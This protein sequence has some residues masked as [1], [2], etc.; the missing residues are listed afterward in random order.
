MRRLPMIEPDVRGYLDENKELS[1]IE[2]AFVQLDHDYQVNEVLK[3]TIGDLA[4]YRRLEV[5]VRVE[6]T[7]LLAKKTI[8]GKR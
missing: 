6:K 2:D 5:L 7:L 3:E 8:W 1:N 4:Y